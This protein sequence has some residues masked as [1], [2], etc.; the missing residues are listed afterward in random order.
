MPHPRCLT[1][2]VCLAA[3]RVSATV[4][5]R[6][7]LAH[8]A[9]AMPSRRTARPHARW[10]RILRCLGILAHTVERSVHRKG[11][12]VDP[13]VPSR[14]L[15]PPDDYVSLGP[16]LAPGFATIAA[17]PSVITVATGAGSPR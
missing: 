10:A 5:A 15:R 7:S 8:L 1:T 14:R 6:G 2:A 3:P 16:G 17:A 9:L 13:A 11:D 4:A 12:A